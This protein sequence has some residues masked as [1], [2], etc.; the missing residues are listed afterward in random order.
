MKDILKFHLLQTLQLH[1]DRWNEFEISITDLAIYLCFATPFGCYAPNAI[2]QSVKE[3][4]RDGLIKCNRLLNG[5][6]F[7]K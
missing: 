6:Y 3:L 1:L 5:Y 2:S 7:Y 4:E